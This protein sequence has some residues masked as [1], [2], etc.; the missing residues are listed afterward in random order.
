M[1]V[2]RIL[3]GAE[4]SLLSL[5]TRLPDHGWDVLLTCPPGPVAA[6]AEDMGV[7]VERVPWRTIT[8]IS[9]KSTGAKRFRPAGAA[10]SLRDTGHNATRLSGLIRRTDATAV[11]S[12]S[13]PSHL[14]VALAAQLSGVRALWYL[15]DIVEPGLGRQVLE[16]GSR[17]VPTLLS[18][19]RAVTHAIEHR[20][21]ITIPEPI[22]PPASWPVREPL[23]GRRPVVGYLGR[24]DPR[25]GVEDVC[26]AAASVDADFLIAGAPH[27]APLA[28]AD[29]LRALAEARAPGRV[30][31][32]GAVP[33]PWEFLAQVDVLAVPS[34][35]EPWGRVA[36]EAIMTGIPVVAANTG[37]LPEI[38]RDGRDGLLY[39]PGDVPALVAC[40]RRLLDDPARYEQFAARARAERDRFDPAQHT[41]LVAQALDQTAELTGEPTGRL[42]RS[43]RAPDWSAAPTHRPQGS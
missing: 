11:L 32:L 7:P 33:S 31:F 13:L 41:R 37:G 12:N 39:P 43:V 21:I 26:Y 34:R 42:R 30:R 2:G 36:A 20:R 23:A 40:L 18:I 1:S 28:Y 19:S 27:L 6:R 17:S 22:E 38:V 8:G 5:V 15:R 14:V 4:L 35:R 24:L 3:G 9:D 25:K 16:L 10:A 29:A